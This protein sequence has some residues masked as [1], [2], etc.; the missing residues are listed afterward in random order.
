MT[1][2]RRSM[3][4]RASRSAAED[5]DGPRPLRNEAENGPQ[6]HRLAGAGSADDAQDFAAIGVDIETLEDI[7]VA[8]AGRQAAH[9][10][11]G[12][13]AVRLSFFPVSRLVQH[14]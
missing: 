7:P 3:A 11:H 4:S 14:Q 6:K 10:D 8:E 2:S 5:L 12:L 1:P 13:A 9:P